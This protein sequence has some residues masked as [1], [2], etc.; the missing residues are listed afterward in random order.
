M[1]QRLGK[2]FLDRTLGNLEPV[3]D[4]PMGQALDPGEN[5]D[6][7]RPLRQFLDCRAKAVEPAAGVGHAFRR[8]PLPRQSR[9]VFIGGRVGSLARL[10]AD[11]IDREIAGGAIEERAVVDDSRAAALPMLGVAQEGLLRQIR[12]GVGVA[13][14]FGEISLKLTPVG[15]E[16]CLDILAQYTSPDPLNRPVVIPNAGDRGIK[17]PI[18]DENHSQHFGAGGDCRGA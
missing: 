8:R 17:N 7:P 9:Q 12:G 10:L 14:F 13:Q 16:Q 3:G 1:P 6:L 15:E 5:E 2:V 18:S 4:F 11:V